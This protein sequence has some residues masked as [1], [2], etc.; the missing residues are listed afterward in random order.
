MQDPE[1]HS[2]LEIMNLKFSVSHQRKMVEDRGNNVE[3]PAFTREMQQLHLVAKTCYGPETC[4]C[5]L[6]VYSAW[7][8]AIFEHLTSS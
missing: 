3:S 6:S 2:F 7:D 8:G 5:V 4:D 1:F